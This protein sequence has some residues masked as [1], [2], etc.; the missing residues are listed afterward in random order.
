M[1]NHKDKDTF[2]NMI[3]GC[4]KRCNITAVKAL[5]NAWKIQDIVYVVN[6]INKKDYNMQ[7]PHNVFTSNTSFL[8]TAATDYYTQPTEPLTDITPMINP[9]PLFLTNGNTMRASHKGKLP[10]LLLISNKNK[11]CQICP[12]KNNMS[13]VSLGKLY[14]NECEAKINK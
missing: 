8:D 4:R 11:T 3:G 10:N 6:N 12:E 13:L 7:Y 9:D 14:D 1:L 2:K 5:I